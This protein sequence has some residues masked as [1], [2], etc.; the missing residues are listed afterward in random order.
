MASVL[1]HAL[2]LGRLLGSEPWSVTVYMIV[3]IGLKRL[4]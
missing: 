2:P 4:W 1:E 3:K